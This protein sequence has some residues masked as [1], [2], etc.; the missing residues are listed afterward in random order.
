M[1]FLSVTLNGSSLVEGVPALCFVNQTIPPS[2]FTGFLMFASH[3]GGSEVLPEQLD[4]NYQLVYLDA[5]AITNAIVP[6][7]A[8]PNQV[9]AC[10]IA[11]QNCVITLRQQIV[12][13]IQFP[14]TALPFGYSTGLDNGYSNQV[15]LAPYTAYVESGYWDPTYSV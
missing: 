12:D 10:V 6:L 8:V 5:D 2:G 3:Y 11:G 1:L 15:F 4:S 14:D 13:A 7:E 9:L